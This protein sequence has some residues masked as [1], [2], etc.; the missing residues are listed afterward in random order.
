METLVLIYAYTNFR[1]RLSPTSF[2]T[3]ALLLFTEQREQAVPCILKQ[4]LCRTERMFTIMSVLSYMALCTL[5][6]FRRYYHLAV[7]LLQ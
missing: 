6:I 1:A 7:F 2:A 4:T 5:R 3:T